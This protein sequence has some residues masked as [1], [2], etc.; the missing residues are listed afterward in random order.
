MPVP[1]VRV[2][3]VHDELSGIEQTRANM[4]VSS[5]GRVYAPAAQT[6]DRSRRARAT[7]RGGTPCSRPCR[8]RRQPTDRK[9]SRE[10]TCRRSRVGADSRA[11]TLPA[12]PSRARAAG[13]ARSRRRRPDPRSTAQRAH[14]R[15]ADHH[16]VID[17]RDDLVRGGRHARISRAVRG[18]VRFNDVADAKPRGDGAVS[19]VAGALST[20]ITS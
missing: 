18:R 13:P 8:P 15:S 17:K 3:R 2:R 6:E 10:Y 11:R 14:P 20:T 9:R 12:P 16:V 7:S 19:A 1:D 5:P 4:S